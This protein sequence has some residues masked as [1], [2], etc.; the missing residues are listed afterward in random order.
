MA[1][2]DPNSTGIL[3]RVLAPIFI[4]ISILWIQMKQQ[5]MRLLQRLIHKLRS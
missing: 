1:Y 2:V 5:F 3:V 4:L